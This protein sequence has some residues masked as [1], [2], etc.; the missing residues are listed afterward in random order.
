M[1]NELLEI[2]IHRPADGSWQVTKPGDKV[3][4]CST[5][6]VDIAAAHVIDL[7]RIFGGRAIVSYQDDDSLSARLERK[8]RE[9]NAKHSV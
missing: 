6:N 9:E 7:V 1:S 5:P 3:S 4:Y 2:K 8:R